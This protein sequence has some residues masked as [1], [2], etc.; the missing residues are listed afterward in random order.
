MEQ[1][2]AISAAM[3]ALASK[4]IT[5]YH[6]LVDNLDYI[7]VGA[8]IVQKLKKLGDIDNIRLSDGSE[9]RLAREDNKGDCKGKTVAFHE[10]CMRQWI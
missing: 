3:K 1:S 8:D 7:T 4:F 9:Y 6:Q 2:K 10:N 5:S